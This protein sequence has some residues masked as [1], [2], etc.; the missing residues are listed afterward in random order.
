MVVRDVRISL[1]GGSCDCV[2]FFFL[3]IRRPPRSTLDRWSAASDV[4]KRQG[5]H[6]VVQL[7]RE[8]DLAVA[9]RDA[10]PAR[11]RLSLIHLSEPTRPYYISYAAFR[12]KKKHTHI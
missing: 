3:N 2:L 1:V 12:L 5:P 7:G 4:Y 9:E 11:I 10:L 8:E 6:R